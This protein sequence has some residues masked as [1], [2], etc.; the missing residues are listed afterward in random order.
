MTQNSRKLVSCDKMTISSM[1]N[2]LSYNKMNSF[3]SIQINATFETRENCLI[4]TT[5]ITSL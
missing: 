5:A 2:N 4:L 1:Y 3:H